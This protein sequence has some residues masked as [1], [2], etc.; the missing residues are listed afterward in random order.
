MDIT[1]IIYYARTGESSKTL[2]LRDLHLRDVYD[3]DLETIFYTVRD[4]VNTE[5]LLSR[6]QR[7]CSDS[8]EFDC[9]TDAYIRFTVTDDCG[10]TNYLKFR[11]RGEYK[12]W[13]S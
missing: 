1:N 8:V 4:A 2:S 12:R 13:K 6:F 10:N 5:D 9:E 3:P 7:L 11:K